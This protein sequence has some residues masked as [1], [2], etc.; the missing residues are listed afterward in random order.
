MSECQKLGIE[1]IN[2][3]SPTKCALDATLIQA[4]TLFFVTHIL[5]VS[6]V[7]I[8]LAQAK[9]RQHKICRAELCGLVVVL[10]SLIKVTLCQ[11]N[12]TS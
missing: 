10:E 3:R 6:P 12:Y 9:E 2:G 11:H 4:A 5:I 1:A 7:D 8:H